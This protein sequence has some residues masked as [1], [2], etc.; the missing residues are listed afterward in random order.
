MFAGGSWLLSWHP[1]APRLPAKVDGHGIVGFP[2]PTSAEL[3]LSGFTLLK[4]FL[5]FLCAFSS[6]QT[7]SESTWAAEGTQVAAGGVGGGAS[8][9]KP[10]VKPK[11]L[12]ELMGPVFIYQPWDPMLGFGKWL[13]ILLPQMWGSSQ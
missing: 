2:A 13:L 3:S 8:P 1:E 12:I 9:G 4:A 10:E 5:H 6:T 7:T 11:L